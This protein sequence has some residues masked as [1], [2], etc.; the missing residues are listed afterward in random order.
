V[1]RFFILDKYNTWYD[2]RLILT[3]KTINEPDP[4]T[5]YINID[6][7]SGSLDLSDALTGEITYKDRTI[8]A[9]FWTDKGN[10]KERGKL[11]RSIITALHGHKIKIIEPDDPSH[12]FYGHVKIKS[13]E[14]IIPYL[15][16]T[17]E[18]TCEPWRYSRAESYRTVEVNNDDVSVIINNNGVKSLSP[19]IIVRGAVKIATDDITV[20]LTDGEY[21]ISDFKLLSGANNINVSGTG[22]VTFFY[23]EADL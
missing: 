23:R 16:F 4:N 18:A 15:K 17:I 13:H 8:S 3:D 21:K 1:E 19:D 12:Y 9:T 6:G 14:N 5:K 11:L 7:M 20:E 10:Y 22:A 2:W